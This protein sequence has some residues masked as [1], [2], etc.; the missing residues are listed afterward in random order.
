MLL[1]IL[2]R[3]GLHFSVVVRQRKLLSGFGIEDI[4][5]NVNM[6]LSVVIVTDKNRLRI[7]K[8]GCFD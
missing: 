5:D 3:P 4:H 6:G 2:Q 8:T 1:A 7:F